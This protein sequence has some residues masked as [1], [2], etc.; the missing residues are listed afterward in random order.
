[1]K[2][3]EKDK[4]NVIKFAEKNVKDYLDS[5]IVIWRDKRDNM[6]NSKEDRLMAVYYIDA[7]QSVRMSL[8]NEQKEA[9]KRI[10]SKG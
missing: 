4:R 5:C 10:F 6:K 3:N 8:F 9:A 2:I 1:M 7:Y